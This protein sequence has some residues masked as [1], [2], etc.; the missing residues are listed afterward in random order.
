M[1]TGPWGRLLDVDRTLEL[2]AI[3]DSN[4]QGSRVAGGIQAAAQRIRAERAGSTLSTLGTLSSLPATASLTDK[5]TSSQ[6]ALGRT[7]LWWPPLAMRYV[8]RPYIPLCVIA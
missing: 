6:Y 4:S 3:L 7:Y 5:L 1:A 8:G 2:P